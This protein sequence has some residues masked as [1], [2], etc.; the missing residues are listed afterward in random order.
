MTK[1]G[2]LPLPMKK[3]FE[4]KQITYIDNNLFRTQI[5]RSPG[6][7][8]LLDSICF[9]RLPFISIKLKLKIK[10]RFKVDLHNIFWKVSCPQHFEIKIFFSFNFVRN[11][12]LMRKEILQ[13]FK[14]SFFNISAPNY[15]ISPLLV[16]FFSFRL[17]S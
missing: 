7:F 12:Y 4:K 13:F 14:P 2:G 1:V 8:T 17:C 3:C 9:Y 15:L 6:K 11:T 5:L 10:K 16:S